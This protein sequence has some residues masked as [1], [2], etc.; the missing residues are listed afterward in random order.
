MLSIAALIAAT[1][2]VREL[3]SICSQIALELKLKETKGSFKAHNS[4]GVFH[5]TL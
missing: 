3:E 4:D 2:A 5:G 1:F